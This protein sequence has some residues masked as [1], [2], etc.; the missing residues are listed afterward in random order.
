[1]LRQPTRTPHPVIAAE[2]EQQ[3]AAARTE[4]ERDRCFR[5]GQIDQLAGDAAQAVAAGDDARLHVIRVLTSAAQTAL[6]D[7]SAAL[8]RLD[9]GTYGSCEACTTPI[10]VE[11][12]EILPSSRFCTRCQ[13]RTESRARR[14]TSW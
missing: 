11:R 9:D 6:A 3:R 1:M 12:L 13:Y 14:K 4:L 2:T 10:D 5:L 8:A 7:V